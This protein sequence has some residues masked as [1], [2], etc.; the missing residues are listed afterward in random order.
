MTNDDDAGLGLVTQ[1][2]AIDFDKQ[3]PTFGHCID[4]S[5]RYSSAKSE[6]G[7]EKGT[8]KCDFTSTSPCR[9]DAVVTRG[10][11]HASSLT[12]G[13]CAVKKIWERDTPYCNMLRALPREHKRSMLSKARP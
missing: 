2:V 5:G 3:V 9:S 7:R 13:N 1:V 11:R 12:G 8:T 4:A 10:M 6:Q